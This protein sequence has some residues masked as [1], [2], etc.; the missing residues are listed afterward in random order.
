MQAIIVCSFKEN[1]W[2]K[3][4]KIAKTWFGAWFRPVGPKFGPHFFFKNLTS[5][6]TRNHGQLSS[7]TIW[8]KT[9][10]PFLRKLSYGR[11]DGQ[12]DKS[13]FIGCSPTNPEVKGAN[14]NTSRKWF[15]NVCIDLNCT[16]SLICISSSQKISHKYAIKMIHCKNHDKNTNKEN[17]NKQ[18]IISS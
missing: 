15:K 13:D 5:S 10:D 4:K 9:D 6:V 12:T 3:L 18:V 17:I 14:F 8:E 7:Y 1:W 2:P 16:Y 11:M